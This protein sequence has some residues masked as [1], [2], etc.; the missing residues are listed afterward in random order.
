MSTRSTISIFVFSI[1]DAQPGIPNT[2]RKWKIICQMFLHGLLKIIQAR[3]KNKHGSSAGSK[4]LIWMRSHRGLLTSRLFGFSYATWPPGRRSGRGYGGRGTPSPRTRKSP[5]EAGLSV[6]RNVTRC[7]QS[8]ATRRT[9]TSPQAPHAVHTRRDQSVPL[10]WESRMRE[11][12][13]FDRAWRR[14]TPCAL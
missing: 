10:A 14:L 6:E 9:H 5:A 13:N 12:N 11:A 4:T 8:S 1:N 3:Q 2:G 7:V